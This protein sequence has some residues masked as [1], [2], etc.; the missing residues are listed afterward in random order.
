MTV[1][2]KIEPCPK[3]G[4]KLEL[5]N[6]EFTTMFESFDLFRGRITLTCPKCGYVKTESASDNE[7][8]CVGKDK[9]T[10]LNVWIPSALLQFIA[11]WNR[12]IEKDMPTFKIEYHGIVDVFG[13]NEKDAKSRFRLNPKYYINEQIKEKGNVRIHGNLKVVRQQQKETKNVKD[14]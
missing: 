4:H 12:E 3:C 8:L 2:C 6:I 1:K 10:N 11:N 7:E 13:V 14:N 5:K 9:E